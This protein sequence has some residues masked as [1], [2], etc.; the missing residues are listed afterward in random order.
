MAR[1]FAAPSFPITASISP[2][3]DNIFNGGGTISHHSRPD[4]STSLNVYNKSPNTGYDTFES[5][6][7]IQ[8]TRSFTT[9]DG[10]WSATGTLSAL[11]NTIT[12]YDESNTANDPLFYINGVAVIPTQTQAPIGVAGADTTNFSIGGLTLV[13]PSF[14]G[15][16]GEIA[17]WDVILTQEESEEIADGV[18]PFVFK[19]DNLKFYAPLYGDLALYEQDNGPFSVPL[20]VGGNTPQTRH[21]NVQLIEHYL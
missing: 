5:T 3:I 10:I 1:I 13:L 18:S 2:S 17:M 6:T 9:Q 15:I 16:I 11:H 8:F 21:L 12:V 4:T 20:N 14:I 7:G 19:R